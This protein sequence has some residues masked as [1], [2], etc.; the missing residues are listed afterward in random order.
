M[1]ICYVQKTQFVST[2]CV[3]SL[4]YSHSFRSIVKLE[5]GWTYWHFKIQ[6]QIVIGGMIE[7]VRE[8]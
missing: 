3:I 6:S 5:K 2:I 4:H 8:R 7:K 1:L